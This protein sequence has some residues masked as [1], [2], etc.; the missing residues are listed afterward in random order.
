MAY[1][2]MGNDSKWLF[3]FFDLKWFPL[4]FLTSVLQWQLQETML[5]VLR[6]FSFEHH[7]YILNYCHWNT[8]ISEKFS[9]PLYQSA[10]WQNFFIAFLRWLNTLTNQNFK[11]LVIVLFYFASLKKW[12][13]PTKPWKVHLPLLL[14]ELFVLRQSLSANSWIS[15]A[16]T[17]DP[18]ASVSYSARIMGIL[19]CAQFE[20]HLLLASCN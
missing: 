10:V 15:M 14:R 8:E 7:L 1:I 6:D 5:R 17:L 4:L 20:D 13:P 9:A 19:Y 16:W 12:E 3:N 2:Y 18:S 11:I